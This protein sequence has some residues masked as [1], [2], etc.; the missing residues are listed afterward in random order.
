MYIHIYRIVCSPPID[1]CFIY[2]EKWNLEKFNNLHNIKVSKWGSG[3]W[4]CLQ[5]SGFYLLCY[6]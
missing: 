5:D 4:P 3:I 1:L 6:T 2:E